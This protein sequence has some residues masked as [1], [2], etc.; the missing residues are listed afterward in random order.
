MT[1]RPK[2]PFC[3]AGK[4]ILKK[5]LD[6]FTG[7]FRVVVELLVVELLNQTSDTAGYALVL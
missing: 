7:Q 2:S 5:L 6:K 1:F 3:L 4:Q